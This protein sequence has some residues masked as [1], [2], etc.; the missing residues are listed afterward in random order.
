MGVWQAALVRM[1]M[2]QPGP[3]ITSQDRAILEWVP[4]PGHVFGG[5]VADTSLISLKL[6]RDKMKQYQKKVILAFKFYEGGSKL[7]MD[8]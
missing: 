2:A 7:M 3:K 5:W 8:V 4:S 1:G 6:Q